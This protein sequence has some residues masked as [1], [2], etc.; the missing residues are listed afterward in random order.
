VAHQ[1]QAGRGFLCLLKPSPAMAAAPR[2]IADALFRRDMVGPSFGS[3]AASL[4]GLLLVEKLVMEFV[5][6]PWAPT[7]ESLLLTWGKIPFL[8]AGGAAV[9]NVVFWSVGLIMA[10]P[11]LVDTKQWKIQPNRSLDVQSLLS[12]LPLVILNSNLGALYAPFVLA[13]FLPE[14]AFDMRSLPSMRILLRDIIVWMVAEEF[15]F[16]HIHRLFHEN[17]KLYAAVHKLHHTWTSPVSFVA[18]YCHPLEHIL[19]NVSPLVLGPVLCGSH[20]VSI[21]VFV[22]LGIVHTL[23]VHSGYWVC[24][25][26]GMHDEHHAKFTVNYGVLGVLDAWYG[27]YRLPA[28][29]AGSGSEQKRS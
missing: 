18:I 29:A 4:T 15:A 11:A 6:P 3:I 8:L 10:L 7:V 5:F 9:F 28:G 19:C 13:A 24:D 1:F 2:R 22:F 25:D 16:F 27:T 12:S 14:S 26:N 21:S 23:A 20:V 17:K